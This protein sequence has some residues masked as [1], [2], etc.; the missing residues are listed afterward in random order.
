MRK[1]E[2]MET[3]TTRE[4]RRE[5]GGEVRGEKEEKEGIISGAGRGFS[6]TGGEF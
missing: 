4:E 1:E 5:E 2:G 6:S 3:H